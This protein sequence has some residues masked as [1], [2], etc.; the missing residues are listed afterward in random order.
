MI[1]HDQIRTEVISVLT[2]LLKNKIKRFFNGRLVALNATEQCPALS[3]YL[4]DIG[5]QEVSMC[6]GEFD[7]LL[8][9]AIYLKPNSGEG[10]LDDI[11]ET[12]RLAVRNSE[13]NFLNDISLKGYRY[14]YDEEQATWISATVQFAVSYDD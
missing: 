12:V 9:V 13:F 3:I 14:D 8:N 2:P 10:E 7:A 4:E 11:A 5:A 1:I 6:D